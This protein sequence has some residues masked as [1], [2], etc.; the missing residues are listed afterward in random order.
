MNLYTYRH[1][2]RFIPAS[3]LLALATSPVLANPAAAE[4]SLGPIVVTATRTATPS[5]ELAAAVTVIDRE[6]IE[7]SGKNRVAEILRSVPGLTLIQQGGPGQVSSVFMRGTESNHVLVL[8]DGVEIADPSVFGG[9]VD[10]SNLLLENVERI[11]IVRGPQSTLYGSDAIGGVI[12]IFTR[13]SDGASYHLEIGEFATVNT[14]ASLR[15]SFGQHRFGLSA[16]VLDT[17][18]TSVANP[19]RGNHDE[20]DAYRNTT[21]SLQWASQITEELELSFNTRFQDADAEL[22]T[23]FNPFNPAE[24]FVAHDPDFTS[25]T[26]QNFSR[27]QGEW[28]SPDSRWSQRVGYSRSSHDRRTENGPKGADSVPS[29]REFTATKSKFDWQHSHKLQRHELTFGAE[30]EDDRA[31]TAGF[32]ESVRTTGI[33][34]QDRVRFTPRFSSSFGLRYDKHDLFG[35]E[36]TWK[37]APLFKLTDATRLKASYGT[38]F[39]APSLAELFDNS[40]GS[41]NPDLQPEESEGWDIGIEHDFGNSYVELIYFQ[42]DIDNLISFDLSTFQNNNLDRAET[43]GY[44][45]IAGFSPVENLDLRISYTRTESEDV[46]TGD[47]LLRRPE[48][49][50]ALH[51]NWQTTRSIRLG[52]AARYVGERE[53]FFGFNSFPT[54]GG[55]GTLE[56]YKV[57]DFNAD[58]QLNQ[59]WRLT[60]RVDNLSDESFE[61]AAGY[62]APGRAAYAG[63]RWVS[64]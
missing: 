16:N 17:A 14:G 41:A 28:N 12:Q 11:E 27:L 47:P 10:F 56:S 59:S 63:V 52:L 6:E 25:E 7:A 29:E 49:E 64:K 57:F 61:E 4:T 21:L 37:I 3:L 60:L 31:R 5:D 15:R 42:N 22:D 54:T 24:D 2:T 23:F 1:L 33:Y 32:A 38:G 51:I 58:Y 53:D 48:D 30:L 36:T 34:V 50:A 62:A 26:D 19:E 46:S 20:K 45:A 43:K 39:K 55:I 8:I 9:Q 44:E 40:F 13:Q 18:G 35:E